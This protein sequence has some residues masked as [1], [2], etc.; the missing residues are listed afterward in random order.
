MQTKHAAHRSRSTRKHYHAHI[1]GGPP[2]ALALSLCR[3]VLLGARA[4]AGASAGF[5]LARL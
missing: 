3:E 2:T 4:A 1:P 5:L